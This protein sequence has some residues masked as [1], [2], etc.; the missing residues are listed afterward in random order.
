MQEVQDF[1]IQER[2]RQ[3]RRSRRDRRAR[4]TAQAAAEREPRQG[5]TAAFSAIVWVPQEEE[6]NM[7]I[8][9]SPRGI[10][11]IFYYEGPG[12]TRPRDK[13]IA[14]VPRLLFMK[15]SRCRTAHLSICGICR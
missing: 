3:Q 13:S 9:H 11:R 1:G 5:G 4:R 12:L 7:P 10:P 6:E 2:C 8:H 14:S 15:P